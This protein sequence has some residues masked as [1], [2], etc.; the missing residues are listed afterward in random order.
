MSRVVFWVHL[1]K[2]QEKN[3]FKERIM[4]MRGCGN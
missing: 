3:G 2:G 4:A 1:L